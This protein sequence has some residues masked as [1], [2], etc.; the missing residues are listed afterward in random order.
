MLN[1]TNLEYDLIGWYLI[2]LP[3]IRFVVLLVTD[4]MYQRVLTTVD[5]LEPSRIIVKILNLRR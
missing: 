1:W 2:L 5:A 3:V 4:D